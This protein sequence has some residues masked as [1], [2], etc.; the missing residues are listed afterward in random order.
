MRDI[1]DDCVVAVDMMGGGT[2]LRIRYRGRWMRQHGCRTPKSGAVVLDVKG[3]LP[4]AG[5]WYIT[6]DK[7]RLLE[8]ISQIR[9]AR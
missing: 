2:A 4:H 5:G 7:P 8:A 1:S 9:E 3:R 6:P